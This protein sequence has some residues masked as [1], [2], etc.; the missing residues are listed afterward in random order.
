MMFSTVKTKLFAGRA[1]NANR[2][3]PKGSI[4]IRITKNHSVLPVAGQT[5][6]PR[7]APGRRTGQV[8][9]PQVPA[10]VQLKATVGRGANLLSYYCR[11]QGPA[12]L[13]GKTTGD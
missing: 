6:V 13:C 3:R 9:K 8:T 10:F 11:F 2:T 4:A 1:C 7:Y 12:S 5:F